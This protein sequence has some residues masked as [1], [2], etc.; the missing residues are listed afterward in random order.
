MGSH[1]MGGL[2]NWYNLGGRFDYL[3]KRKVCTCIFTVVVVFV[4]Q[5]VET[6]FPIK[7]MVN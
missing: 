5:K 6:V 3:S 7:G 1:V 2:V 4:R